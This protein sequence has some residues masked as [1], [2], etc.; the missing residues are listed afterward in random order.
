MRATE[1]SETETGNPTSCNFRMIRN[2]G[3]PETLSR[4]SIKAKAPA[5][6]AGMDDIHI[7]YEI[8]CGPEQNLAYSLPKTNFKYY[9]GN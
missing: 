7:I 8:N 1:T 5:E 6:K 2:S 3:F 4:W 9:N